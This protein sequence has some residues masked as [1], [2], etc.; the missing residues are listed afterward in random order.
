MPRLP[1]TATGTPADFRMWPISAVVVDLPLVPVTAQMRAS[2][3]ARRS[4]WMS[5]VTGTPAA[6]AARTAGCGAGCVS[7]TPGS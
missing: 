2:G 1:P 7:G 6:R 4:S 3:Q 5:P